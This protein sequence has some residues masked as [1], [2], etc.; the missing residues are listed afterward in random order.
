MI[1]GLATLIMAL[2]TGGSIDV[3]YIDKI[4]EGVNKE[5]TDKDR[6]K[7]LDSSLKDYNKALKEFTKDRKNLVKVLKK[8]NLNK[9]TQYEWYKDFFQ[10]CLEERK[11][12]QSLFIDQRIFLQNNIKEDEW[13]KIMKMATDATNK[14]AEKEQAK[15]MKKKDKNI[16]G[17][18]EKTINESIVDE[19]KLSAVSAGLKEYEK[20]NNDIAAAYENINVIDSKFLTDKNATAKQMNEISD[21]LN[22]QRKML[23]LSYIDFLAL[24][25]E[26]A[27]SEEWESII[28]EFNKVLE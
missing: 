22:V 2:F 14:Q 12:F 11:E 27:T 10:L 6:K 1:I 3:Y 13:A 28:K 9:S 26:N 17:S 24:A 25:K 23:Y 20:S 21:A 7:E 15:A 4:E 5:V 19:S 8:K 16:F 18:L